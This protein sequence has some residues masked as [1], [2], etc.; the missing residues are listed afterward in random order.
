MPSQ[1]IA[2]QNRLFSTPADG[3]W[4]AAAAGTI[5]PPG[6]TLRVMLVGEHMV[7]LETRW[8]KGAVGVLHEHD[9]HESIGYLVSGRMKLTIG[10][11]ERIVEAGSAWLHPPGVLHRG[12]ALEDSVQIEVK[13][14]PRRTW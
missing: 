7:M 13:S 8:P 11:E 6:V 12:E 5:V 14:P 3:D 10:N 2:P 4:V 1:P 9:D